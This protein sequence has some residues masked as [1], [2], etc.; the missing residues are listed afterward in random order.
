M[1][2]GLPIYLSDAYPGEGLM[3]AAVQDAIEQNREACRCQDQREVC[4]MYRKE[5]DRQQERRRV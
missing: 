2:Q 1:N 3:L 5:I 4:W